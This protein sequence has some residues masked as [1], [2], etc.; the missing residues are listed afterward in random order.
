M[1]FL[2]LYITCPDESTAFTISQKMVSSRLSACA[3]VFPAESIYW[4]K[5]VLNK[6][7]EWI[8]MLKTSFRLKSVIE[9]AIIELHPAEVPCVTRFESSASVT[10]EKWLEE[11]T[12][13]VK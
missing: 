7:D 6:E 1:S 5:D 9:K 2:L 11:S 3:N 10:Y 8:I 12:S 13:M 4:W